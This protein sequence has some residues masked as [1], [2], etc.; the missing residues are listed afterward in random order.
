MKTITI[1]SISLITTLSL[2]NVAIAEQATAE[3]IKKVARLGRH[4]MPFDLNQTMHVFSKTKNGGVQHVI[5]K[6]ASNKAQITLIRQHL[7]KIAVDFKQNN[8]SDPTK[9]HG[10]EM[11]G[12]KALKNAKPGLIVI[13]YQN[14][15]NGAE[16]SYSTKTP[17]LINALHQWFDAQL[18][19]HAKHAKKGH[20]HHKM[21]Q[22]K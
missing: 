9:I 17:L 16:I 18:S 1:L 5:S 2:S 4:V 6:D 22:Q 3:R 13:Q 19:D 20:Q 14:L 12:L 8:F 15:G 11:P 7:K 10:R 21:H